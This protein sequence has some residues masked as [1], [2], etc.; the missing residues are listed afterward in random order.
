MKSR[1]Q[2]IDEAQMEI[3]GWQAA[4]EKVTKDLIRE[5]LEGNY[6]SDDP[7]IK[8]AIDAEGGIEE[9]AETLWSYIEDE[10]R[11]EGIMEMA[12]YYTITIDHY[13]TDSGYSYSE[14]FDDGNSDT[15]MTARIWAKSFEDNT[16]GGLQSL[17]DGD[18]W[19]T[20]ICKLYPAGAD[21]MFDNPIMETSATVEDGEIQ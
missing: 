2:W 10:L 17:C 4:G 14:D 13:Q 3:S 19:I 21:P 9:Y 16:D 5:E 20:I 8:E 12:F 6:A 1:Q 11:K 15:E 7:Y 18:G